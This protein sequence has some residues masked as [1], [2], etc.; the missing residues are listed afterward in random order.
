VTG[1][2]ARQIAF[3]EARVTALEEALRRRSE[4]LRLIQR[5]ICLPDLVLVSRIVLGLPPSRGAYDPTFWSESTDVV[6]ADVED[7]LLDLWVAV[8]PRGGSVGA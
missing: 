1:G 3:L 8:T 5:H 2:S 6:E 4:E 7:T